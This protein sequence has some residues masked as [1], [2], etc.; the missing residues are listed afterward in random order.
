MKHLQ[1]DTFFHVFNRA[2]GNEKLFR[3]DNN[4]RYFI[5]SWVKYTDPIA[6]TYAC[7]LM[8]DHFH[9]L[10]KIKSEKVLTDFFGN[11]KAGLTD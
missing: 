4:Y 7:C 2:N 5:R 9:A 3:N 11:K 8:P 1:P 6:R 10:I